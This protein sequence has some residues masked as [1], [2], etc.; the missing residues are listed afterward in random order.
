MGSITISE[1]WA[2]VLAAC[3]A[4]AAISKALEII[5]SWAGSDFRT[6]VK[7]HDAEIIEIKKRLDKLESSNIEDDLKEHAQLLAKD[8]D[9]L[10]SLEEANVITMQTMLALVQHE[11]DGNNVAGLRDTR[12]KLNKYLT[13]H[14][15]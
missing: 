10:R 4:I 3:A 7:K 5:K 1:A 14:L 11:L 15:H 2:W 12:D 6:M 13:Q 9:R 8:E